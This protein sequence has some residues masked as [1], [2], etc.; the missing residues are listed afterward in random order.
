M[1]TSDRLRE[2]ASKV[3]SKET[4]KTA[5]CSKSALQS[6][7]ADDSLDGLGTIYDNLPSKILRCFDQRSPSSL[8]QSQANLMLQHNNVKI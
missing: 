5:S 8:N 1:E 3:G 4:R 2:C 7:V 6:F